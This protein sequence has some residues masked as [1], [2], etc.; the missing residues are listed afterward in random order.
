MIPTGDVYE[1]VWKI[2][3]GLILGALL[4][5]IGGGLLIWAVVRWLT[6][7]SRFLRRSVRTTTTVLEEVGEN[8]SAGSPHLEPADGQPG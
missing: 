8:E 4:G 3:A 7:R 6:E 5:G 2:L 1:A